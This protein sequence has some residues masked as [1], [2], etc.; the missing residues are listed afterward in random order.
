MALKTVWG[1]TLDPGNVLPEYPRPQLVRENWRSLNG[2]WDYAFTPAGV[3]EQPGAWDGKI[4]V[5]F[6]PEAPLSGVERQLQPEEALWYRRS[7]SVSGLLPAGGGLAA[8]DPAVGTGGRVRQSRAAGGDLAVGDP[9]VGTGGRVLLHFGAVDQSCTVTV[10]GRPAGRH[11]GGYL[12]F[13]LDIT[14]LL[15]P[16]QEQELVVR[17]LDGSETNGASRGKQKLERGGIWYTAQSGIWQTVWLEAV[18]MT[19]IQRVVITP[20]A[21][22][23]G[24]EFTVHAGLASGAAGRADI[25]V[26]AEGKDVAHGTAAP[27]EPL[28]LRLPE[29]RLW[30]PGDPFLYSVSVRLGEDTVQS[31]FGLRTFGMGADGGGHQRLLLNGRPYFHAGLLDQG[32]WPDGLYTAPADAAMIHDIETAKGLGFTMLRKHIKI[33]P[34]RWYYHC[35]RLGML[36]WQDLAN[37]GLGDGRAPEPL[38]LPGRG[39]RSDRR[40]AKFGR[41]DA[42]GR[43]AF[44]QELRE[45]VELLR[46][47]PSIALWVPFNEGWG[48]FDAAAITAELRKLDP[49]RGIDHASGWHDQGAGDAKSLH[50]YAVPFHIRRRWQRDPRAIVLSE[51]G[52]FSLPVPGHTW[53]S[54]VFGYGKTLHSRKE[55]ERAFT[56]LHRTQIEPAVKQGLAAAVY[57]QLADVEDEVNGLLT[58]DRKVL[59]LDRDTAR[60]INAALIQGLSATV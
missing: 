25:T 22:L 58:Y 19:W 50:V 28:T 36:V 37:G 16:S 43:E 32:Y 7:F 6:S 51:F 2:S 27:G 38:P 35:D 4:L 47:V 52:G 23:D 31:Y 26:T 48:Q 42:A 53:N 12:P 39:S 14:D 60:E 46:S 15:L 40:Y 13:S 9:A 10:N 3:E 44:R 41:S 11:D 29:P 21:S 30:S 34:L 57:T 45:T 59:K 17:V 5:P 8:G 18:P 20:L 24:A 1:E 56:E 55:L 33:E 54:K 49:T